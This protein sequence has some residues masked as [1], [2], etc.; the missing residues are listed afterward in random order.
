VA[1]SVKVTKQILIKTFKNPAFFIRIW[2]GIKMALS[3]EGVIL[4]VIVATLAAIVYSLRFLVLMERRLLKIDYNI[5]N[6]QRRAA[7]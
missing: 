3:L 5:E 6:C 2:R 1:E 4:A 7:D